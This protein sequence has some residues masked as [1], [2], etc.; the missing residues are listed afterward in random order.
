MKTI[1][2]KIFTLWQILLLRHKKYKVINH[3]ITF[4]FV[5]SLLYNIFNEKE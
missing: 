1:H 5:F 3:V 2:E 4:H